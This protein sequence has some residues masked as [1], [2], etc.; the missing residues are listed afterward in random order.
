MALAAAAA[1]CKRDV[2][3][4]PPAARRCRGTSLFLMKTLISITAAVALRGM[5]RCDE[6]TDN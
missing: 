1:A 2:L 3:A 5:D 6:N 4:M